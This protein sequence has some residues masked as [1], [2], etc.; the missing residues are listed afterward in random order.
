MI[1][2]FERRFLEEKQLE[3][4]YESAPKGIFLQ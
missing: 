1:Q 3:I 2:E 4:G